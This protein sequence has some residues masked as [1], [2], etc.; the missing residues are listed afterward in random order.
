MNTHSYH[1][2]LAAGQESTGGLGQNASLHDAADGSNGSLA[3]AIRDTLWIV[4]PIT[5][6]YA[7][8]FVI[9][10]LGNVVTCIVI[11]RNKSMHTATNYYLFSLAISDLLLLLTGVP[12]D[13]YYIWYRFPYPF[14]DAV[15]KMASF[16]AE[17]SAN[18]TVLTITA[19]TVERYIA[20][21][22]PFQSHTMSKLS[23]AVRFVLAIWLI[24]VSL[25]IP[26]ALAMQIDKQFLVCTVRQEQAKHA[27]FISTVLVFVLPMGV[28]TVLY[29]LIWLQLRRSK[30]VRHR[31]HRSSSVRLKCSFLK[32]GSQQ[33]VIT[34]HDCE[35]H[36]PPPAHGYSE[37]AL[38][39]S[40]AR[41]GGTLQTPPQHYA[42]SCPSTP[43]CKYRR[44][45]AVAGP[46]GS[47]HSHSQRRAPSPALC[48]YGCGLAAG[49]HQHLE[50]QL[51]GGGA[52]DGRINYANRTQYNSTRHVVKMLVA[53][54]IAF[55]V[56]WAPF[57]A[58]RLMAVYANEHS[59]NATIRAAFDTLTYVSGIL[60]YISTCINPVL[61]NI[62]SHKFREA[63]KQ[64][65]Q[66]DEPTL[67]TSRRPP[68][69]SFR[70]DG[71]PEPQRQ[72]GPIRA[73]R[74]ADD[75]CFA[76]QKA[77]RWSPHRSHRPGPV[78]GT[79]SSA[80]DVPAVCR[81]ER[82]SPLRCVY[83]SLGASGRAGE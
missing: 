20:I 66:Q 64:Q 2:Q 78:P 5:I 14:G 42:S 24:A 50:Q 33:T 77:D 51:S 22:K 58:Q 3:Y 27:F 48:R 36:E 23:R 15:C 46:A 25:A 45:D 31:A 11:A 4:V 80:P 37:S 8:I 82:Y 30:V 12:Q 75:L 29:I 83:P 52:E 32:R 70:I 17:T 19:F 81:S 61:Y 7:T 71:Q 10:V 1:E 26:Q 16:A 28:I 55:F 18:A 9:G 76:G 68:I 39:C 69:V 13:I 59:Q 21:C 67:R 38:T 34:L 73:H 57:H 79:T 65:Q 74:T 72:I 35:P 63:F 44:Q 62:M 49:S 41:F 53:V 56:C 6:I 47:R 40:P 60:Y 43:E 54:V